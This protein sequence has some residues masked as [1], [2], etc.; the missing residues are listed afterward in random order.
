MKTIINCALIKLMKPDMSTD[1]DFLFD[2]YPGLSHVF[3]GIIRCHIVNKLHFLDIL[4]SHHYFFKHLVFWSLHLWNT[5]FS[6]IHRNSGSI[7]EWRGWWEVDERKIVIRLLTYM[8]HVS[9]LWNIDYIYHNTPV[10][11]VPTETF[12]HT[13]TKTLA[14]TKWLM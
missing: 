3:N 9:H 12:D 13:T 4:F 5:I 1:N 14:A 7:Y 2:N 8:S 10:T 6:S 11:D